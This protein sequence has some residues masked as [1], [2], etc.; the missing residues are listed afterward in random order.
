MAVAN[1]MAESDVA[2]FRY[3]VIDNIVHV[4]PV[5]QSPQTQLN[6]ESYYRI[7]GR[8]TDKLQRGFNI[9]RR[10]DGTTYKVVVK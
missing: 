1:G 10:T 8:Q 9:I 6:P 3:T 5:V 4:E 2:E 7:D